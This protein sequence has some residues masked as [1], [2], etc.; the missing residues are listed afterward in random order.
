MQ[1]AGKTVWYYFVT[2]DNLKH[3]Q[4]YLMAKG[5]KEDNF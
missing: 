4:S 3:N 1:R 5:V 2:T